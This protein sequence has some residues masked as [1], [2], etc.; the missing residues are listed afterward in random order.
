MDTSD[1]ASTAKRRLRTN[2]EKRQIIEEAL[3]PGASVAAVARKHGLNANLRFGWRR[4]HKQGML[5][6]CREPAALLPVEVKT[7]TLLPDRPSRPAP[8]SASSV[9]RRRRGAGGHVEVELPGG[10]TVRVHG[11]VER[12]ALSAVLSALRVA[13]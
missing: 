10:I 12:D 6:Q 4:L 8:Q 2:A 9:R 11:W 7:P 1:Q 13:R 3:V 5:D